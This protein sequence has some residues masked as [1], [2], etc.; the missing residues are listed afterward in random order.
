LRVEESYGKQHPKHWRTHTDDEEFRKATEPGEEAEMALKEAFYQETTRRLRAVPGVVSVAVMNPP[1][2]TK[3]SYFLRA[4]IVQLTSDQKHTA[5]PVWGLGLYREI[6][7]NSFSVLGIHLLAGRNFLASD[8]P[9]QDDWKSVYHERDNTPRPTRVG[10]VNATFAHSAW[11]NQNPLGKTFL[12]IWGRT[13]T[14]VGVVADIHESRDTPT[15]PPTLYEPFTP[16]DRLVHGVTFLV[17]LRPGTNLA[18]LKKAL[19]PVDADAAPPTALPLEESQGNLPLALTL[20]S[21]FSVLGIIVAGLGVYATATLMSAARTRETGIRLAIGASAAQIGRLVLWRSLRLALLALPVGAFGAWVLGL[22]L[23]HW[24]F[25]V[26]AADPVSYLTSAAILLVI[27]L[28][29]GLWPAIR[30]AT[31]DPS[32]A[33]R[34]DG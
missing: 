7:T 6:S 15:I 34:Y 26:G 10:I 19:P 29:A 14:V 22:S 25:Q 27:A 9:P 3:D 12:D 24:L 28:A 21:C 11:P 31:T 5:P 2:L 30:A 18:D 20:L 17:K 16:S 13:T 1:P 8:I 23:K 4:I 32:T 33:L